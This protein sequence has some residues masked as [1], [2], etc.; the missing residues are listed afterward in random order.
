MRY[1]F[2]LF[3][4]LLPFL[5]KAGILSLLP[6]NQLFVLKRVQ[7]YEMNF[8]IQINPQIFFKKNHENVLCNCICLIIKYIIFN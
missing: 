1:F 8:T 5:L 3:L 4:S 7:M 2:R 6:F